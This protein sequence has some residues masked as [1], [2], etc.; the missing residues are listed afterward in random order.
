MAERRLLNNGETKSKGDTF[1]R[2]EKRS[3]QEV[4]N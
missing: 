3:S 2:E 4:N 1:K